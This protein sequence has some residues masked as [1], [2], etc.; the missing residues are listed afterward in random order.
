MSI[1][2]FLKKSLLK[3]GRCTKKM[4]P[5]PFLKKY[6]TFLMQYFN[7]KKKSN[8]ILRISDLYPCFNDA[9]NS[10]PFDP[11]Y[12]Y[13]SAWVS[14]KIAESKVN[15]H[16]DVGSQIYL[17]APLSGFIKVLFVDIR[18][19]EAALPN[20]ECIKGSIIN[21]PFDDKSVSS[22]SSLHVVEHIGLGRYGDE[23]D[24][25]GAKKACKELQRVLSDDGN[26]YISVPVGRERVKFN[27]HRIFNPF[28]II[29]YFDELSLF[30][31][32][33]VD[34]SGKYY[35]KYKVEDCASFYYGLGLFH[36]R[37]NA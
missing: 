4:N 14:A 12:F 37:R 30:D 9:T 27:A 32:G 7:Y 10:T 5:Y 15:F 35:R 20:L 36:F 2:D 29:K 21:L 3:A 1:Y 8:E 26:L 17:I 13:Q 24:P 31:F 34:D 25:L 6:F 23:I 28:T 22:I 16:V 11:H 33:C 19:L 18:K